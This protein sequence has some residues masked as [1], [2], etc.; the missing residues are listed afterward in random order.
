MK[1]DRGRPVFW[2]C[3]AICSLQG[4][5]GRKAEMI[6]KCD[7]GTHG[8]ETATRRALDQEVEFR[9]PIEDGTV[10]GDV[11]FAVDFMLGGLAPQQGIELVRRRWKPDR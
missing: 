3:S 10:L 2:R 6:C 4:L 11:G 8:D 5:V 1:R 9:P 7:A